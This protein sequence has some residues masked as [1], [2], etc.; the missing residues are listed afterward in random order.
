MI[1]S[2]NRNRLV[3]LQVCQVPA[4]AAVLGAPF[5][6]PC[7]TD[8]WEVGEILEMMVT[9]GESVGPGV[10]NYTVGVTI[11]V[12]VPARPRDIVDDNGEGV[13]GVGKR[14]VI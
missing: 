7:P 14:E 1:D 6:V 11:L 12:V 8:I 5:D 13:L 9:K 2:G 4:R 10:A 3:S